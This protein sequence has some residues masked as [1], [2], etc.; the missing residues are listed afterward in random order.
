MAF[1]AQL[2]RRWEFALGRGFA[3]ARFVVAL[4][5][6]QDLLLGCARDFRLQQADCGHVRFDGM[7]DLGHQRGH[8][9]AASFVVAALGI[10]HGL[11]LFHQKGHIAAFAKHRRQHASQRD[12]P[13]VMVHVFRV[14]EHLVGPAHFVVCVRIQHDVVDGDV[15]GVVRHRR[16]D[17]VRRAE[18]H[19]GPLDALVHVL[20]GGAILMRCRR[21]ARRAVAAIVLRLYHAEILDFAF[22]FG[23]HAAVPLL[24]RS[25]GW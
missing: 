16:F 12:H 9:L 25:S 6:R 14:D 11:E 20:N 15:Q 18:Q 5:L 21:F 3:F 22:D 17:L 1:H 4:F 13:L 7:A 10:E 8:K 19:P 23:R 2:R 24:C